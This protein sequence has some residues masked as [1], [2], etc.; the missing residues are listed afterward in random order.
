MLDLED[1]HPHKILSISS[2][3]ALATEKAE[4][5]RRCGNDQAARLS[6]LYRVVEPA[7]KSANEAPLVL[8]MPVRSIERS[9]GSLSW[10]LDR[11]TM[12]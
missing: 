1:G 4:R 2:R 10:I 7:R 9:N 12:S 8:V 3:I 5:T 6:R 11:R